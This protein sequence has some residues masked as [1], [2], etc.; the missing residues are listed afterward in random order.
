MVPTNKQIAVLHPFINNKGGAVNMMIYLSTFL[1]KNNNNVSLY[2]FSYD[3]LIFPLDLEVVFFK[4]FKLVSFFK[5]AYQI[6]NCDYI[7]IG[8]SPMQFVGVFSK[9]FFASKAKLIWWHHHYPWYYSQNANVFV[10][11]KRLLEKIF[12]KK[13]DSVI[14]NSKYL[15]SSIKDI[16][17]ID[18]KILYPV[19]DN[20]FLSYNNENKNTN[21]NPNTLFTY[22][23]WGEGK[24]IDLIFNVYDNL[25]NKSRDLV[26]IVGG[27]GEKLNYYKD[28]YKNEKSIKFLG[29]VDKTQIIENLEKSSLFLFPSKIDSFGL[30]ILESMSIGV[31]V[32]SFN[33]AGA[34]EIIKNGISGY[35]VDSDD[36]FIEKTY[37]VLNNSE[38]RQNLSIEAVK[39][40]KTFSEDTFYKNLS[41]IF[42][43]MK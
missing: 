10:L 15:Q 36:E 43:S 20:Q 35:L 41:D 40:A 26:L 23:R 7:I 17:E 39:T 31:P 8:N 21:F 33:I 25:K 32:V 30:V 16:Y 38:L 22:G 13:I 4:N 24:N 9:I 28:K 42:N 3:R 19:L 11:L 18:S 37:K 27:E 14:V 12:I 1:S 34:K 6:R 5:I 2:T 29:M